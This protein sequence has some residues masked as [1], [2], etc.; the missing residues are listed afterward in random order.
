MA[1]H[2]LDAIDACLVQAP[3]GSGITGDDLVDHRL[4]QRAGHHPEPFVGH[5]RCRVGHRQQAIAGLHDLP[6]RM[7]HLGQHQGAVGMA[8]LRQFA[9]ALDA[10]I[11]GG[12]QHVGGVARTVM[13]PGHL[14]H[15]QPGSAFGP[16]P[17]IGDQL[18]IDQ[19]VGGHRGVVTT[20]HDAVLQ[21]LAT[22]LQ[23]FEQVREG[24]CRGRHVA[25]TPGRLTCRSELARDGR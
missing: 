3:G 21:A 10:R 6:P 1:G 2:D 5:R 20:G 15:D 13:Y 11:V 16:C 19:V 22:D 18:F 8:G 4:V 23:G 24:G 17:V 25:G 14:Q 9:V 7:E 12:H